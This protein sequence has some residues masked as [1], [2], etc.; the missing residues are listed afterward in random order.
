MPG[1]YGEKGHHVDDLTFRACIPGGTL[2]G[3]PVA[4]AAGIKTLEILR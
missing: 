3:N 2:S 1:A 4:M